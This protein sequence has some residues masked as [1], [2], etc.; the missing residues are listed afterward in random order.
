M[1]NNSPI[2]V[3]PRFFFLIPVWGKAYVEYL[4]T[5][6]LPTLLAPNNLPWLPNRAVSQ[7]T[8]ITRAE[9][10][11]NIRA[12]KLFARLEA[13]IPVKFIFLD[14]YQSDR[15]EKLNQLG[16]ALRLGAG[17][18][19]GRGYCLF[20]HPDG[21]YSDGIDRKSTRL[22]SSHSQISYAVFCLKKQK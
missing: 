1:S 10:E 22:N 21:I 4:L 15:E 18:A 8:F 19:L 7:F 12:S 5:F 2:P 14:F 3:E 13:L 17:E 6:A 16:N 9:D 11:K 20:F